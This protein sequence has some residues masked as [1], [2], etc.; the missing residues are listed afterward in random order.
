MHPK[1]TYFTSPLMRS[2][3]PLHERHVVTDLGQPR[4]PPFSSGPL[5]SHSGGGMPSSPQGGYTTGFLV[6]GLALVVILLFFVQ[7]SSMDMSRVT[8]S[9]GQDWSR[10][11]SLGGG[12][13]RGGGGRGGG[14]GVQPLELSSDPQ[15][16][17]IQ[18]LTVALEDATSELEYADREYRA[19]RTRMKRFVEIEGGVGQKEGVVAVE[20]EE[21]AEKEERKVPVA[22]LPPPTARQAAAVVGSVGGEQLPPAPS[23]PK[24]VAAVSESENVGVGGG[25]GGEKS[26]PELEE[27]LRTLA[28]LTP[29]LPAPTQPC[30]AC[31]RHGSG[32]Q[33]RV[34]LP[35]P[36]PHTPQ[37]AARVISTSLYGDNPR[38]TW[39]VVRN[40]E[41][42][43][44][45]FPGWHLRVYTRSDM[46]PPEDIM[47]DLKAL[48]ADIVTLRGEEKTSGF[49]MNWRFL[50]A[51]DGDVGTFLC[52]DADSR[53]SLRDRWAAEEWLVGGK[54]PFHVVR[55]H[56]SHSGYKLMG[57]TWGARSSVFRGPLQP[58]SKTLGDYVARKGHG[59]YG[60]DIDF[61]SVSLTPP[62]SLP[63]SPPPLSLH[64]PTHTSQ[65]TPDPSPPPPTYSIPPPP[66]LAGDDVASNG[67]V[68]REAARHALV[69][70]GEPWYPRVRLPPPPR[71]HRARGGRVHI[72]EQCRDGAA[73]RLEFAAGVPWGPRLR[74]HP[75]PGVPTPW[76]ECGGGLE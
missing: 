2:P 18:E 53:V 8:S 11:I 7:G 32:L 46:M 9:T 67:Q 44:A 25:G 64:P 54:E 13:S 73:D 59:D 51:D 43:P 49:G 21:E 3:P 37:G 70:R 58:L 52:R 35:A 72:R 50:V 34:C 56:P 40:A 1:V 47:A 36:C 74:P 6:F 5:D 68:G 10:F 15:V 65:Q 30:R 62:L 23:A 48:G 42:M 31:F 38:Y 4:S 24:G 45:V 26:D 66:P 14:V 63:P 69:W 41:L 76:C 61:L 55:D 12:R 28:P 27:A 19:L 39:G 17:L 71:W 60:A 20:E 57:G 33:T 29:T 16:A 75:H 22:P